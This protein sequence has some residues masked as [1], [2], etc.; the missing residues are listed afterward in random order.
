MVDDCG[1]PA[2]RYREIAR[3]LRCI[4]FRRVSFDLCR[5]EQLLALAKGFD[6]F[7]DR[8]EHPDEDIAA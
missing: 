3:Q 2:D 5:K 1:L 4:A 8:I 7:A 6:R